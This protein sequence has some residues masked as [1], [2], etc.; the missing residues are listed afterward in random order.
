MSKSLILPTK[1]RVAIF[2]VVISLPIDPQKITTATTKICS[3]KQKTLYIQIKRASNMDGKLRE[4]IKMKSLH[5]LTVPAKT[6]DFLLLFLLHKKGEMHLQKTTT[7]KTDSSY[8][9]NTMQLLCV[10]LTLL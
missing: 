4:F 7:T 6:F 10:T 8:M 5:E 2:F 9:H 1:L 3:N